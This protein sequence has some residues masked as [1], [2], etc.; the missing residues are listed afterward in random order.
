[1]SALHDADRLVHAFLQ[2]GPAELSQPLNARIRAE[3]HETKQRTVFRPWRNASMPRTLWVVAPLAA[4]VIAIGGLLVAISGRRTP[5]P[6]TAPSAVPSPTAAPTSSVA[7]TPYPLA[8]GEA[9]IVIGQTNH[10]TLVRSDGSGRHD[11]LTNIGVNVIDPV[12]SPDGRQIV[13]DGNGTRGSQLYVVDAD[14]TNLRQLTPTPDGCPN[15]N[16]TE[17]VNPAW[18]P[19]G[20]RVAYIAPQHAAGAYVRAALML[21]DVATGATTEVYTTDQDGLGRP[22]W[23]PDSK[24][25]ALEI[26]RYTGFPESGSLRDTVIAVVDLGASD[27][28]PKAITEPALL[29]GYPSW[30]PALDLIVFR[31]N[32][33]DNGTG[34]LLDPKAPSDLYTIHPDGSALTKV[35][36]NTVGGQVVRAPSWTPDG[37]ILYTVR[38]PTTGSELLRLIDADGTNVTSATGTTDTSGQGHWRPGS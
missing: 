21:I 7:P 5:A 19:D 35:T 28:T 8:A 33:V 22:T 13:F 23:S 3:V 10:A 37:R 36:D 29:G 16:C 4:V 2:E 27:H 31:S 11:I 20:T 14:G 12:W 34:D 6:T 25:I 30:H 18:S 38:D 9:W 32:R 26:D 1:L 17:A 24:S 15:G